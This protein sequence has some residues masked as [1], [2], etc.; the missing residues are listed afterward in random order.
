MDAPIFIT[1][2]RLCAEW[3]ITHRTLARYARDPVD[4]FPTHRPSGWTR[5]FVLSEVMAWLDR[6]RSYPQNMPASRN[7]DL[8]AAQEKGRRARRKAI[9]ARGKRRLPAA[10]AARSAKA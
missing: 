1:A 6:R 5:V 7:P 10:G 9:A 8:A 4:P 3:G 2:D